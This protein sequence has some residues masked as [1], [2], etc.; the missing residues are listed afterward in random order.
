MITKEGSIAS[1]SVC[2]GKGY[3]QVETWYRGSSLKST[4]KYTVRFSS[5]NG[6]V[7]E[8]MDFVKDFSRANNF[9]VPAMDTRQVSDSGNG[10]TVDLL[11]SITT[12]D[13]HS[14]DLIEQQMSRI[15]KALEKEYFSPSSQMSLQF[16]MLRD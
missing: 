8:M 7:D 13:R 9:S 12:N 6:M 14:T 11:L 4:A 5:N 16:A 15:G 1:S 3:L 10:K 2:L